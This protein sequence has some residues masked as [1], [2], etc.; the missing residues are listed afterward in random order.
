MHPAQFYVVSNLFSLLDPRLQII[1]VSFV[2]VPHAHLLLKLKKRDKN[3]K[4]M[5]D[6]IIG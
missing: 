4:I 3:E 1:H 6:K 2:I 5:C